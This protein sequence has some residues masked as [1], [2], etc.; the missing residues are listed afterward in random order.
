MSRRTLASVLSSGLVVV[1]T[2]LSA[3]CG[4][5]M[6]G[7]PSG[8]ASAAS[9]RFPDVVEVAVRGEGGAY[10]FEVTVS[11]P[12]DTPER[13]ADGWRIVAPD[14]TTLGA[15]P[16]AHDHA[17]EQPF[18]RSLDGI[19][20]AE[21]ISRVTVQARDLVNGDGGATVTVRLPDR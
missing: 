15:R 3:G 20:V 19:S 6:A 2:L 17:A 16:L 12:Y 10:D 5:G 1:L 8:A 9:Q 21:G 7:E 18:T 11:S 13:Y 4:G 14:G